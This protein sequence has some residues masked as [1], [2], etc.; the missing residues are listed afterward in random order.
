MISVH[1]GWTVK[2]I[3]IHFTQS[4]K[5]TQ[6]TCIAVDTQHTAAVQLARGSLCRSLQ[7]RTRS[8]QIDLRC[9]AATVQRNTMQCIYEC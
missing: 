7:E 2:V 4:N 3:I 5:N 6:V 9:N 1:G 8:I